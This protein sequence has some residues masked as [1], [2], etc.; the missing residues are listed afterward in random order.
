MKD[1]VTDFH[2]A[3]KQFNTLAG[4]RDPAWLTDLRTRGLSRFQS[5]GFPT[6]RDEDW[7]YTSLKPVQ[8][9]DFSLAAIP[10][11]LD[12]SSCE[13]AL[14]FAPRRLVFVNGL[15]SPEHSSYGD[16]PDGLTM[17]TLAQAMN[18]QNHSLRE[19][20]S[21]ED[22][23]SE[24]TFTGLN[25]AFLRD[26]AY[27][28]LDDHT[29][30]EQPIHLLYIFTGE[31]PDIMTFP[32]NVISIGTAASATILETFIC[33][34]SDLCYFNNT[35]TDVFL[36]ENAHLAYVKAQLNS[37]QAFHID[38]TR[39]RQA[40]SSRLEAFSFNLGARIARNNLSINLDGPDIFTGLDGL[41]AVRENQHVDNHT[42]VNHN[43]PNCASSQLYKGILADH[44][45][46]VFNGKIFVKP[47]AQLTNAY[48]LNRNLMLSP[49]AEADTKP[50]L[51]I[52]A[53]DVRCTHGATIGQ[54][55]E[56]ELFYLRSRGITR[57]A[58]VSMLSHGF[59]D[60]VLAKIKNQTIRDRLR[61][62]LETYFTEIE[63]N[64]TRQP[65]N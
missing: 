36:A 49:N 61:L 51:E 45:R 54:L 40:T 13:D 23:E 18:E 4:P 6:R 27:I 1:T 28:K 31:Q 11:S 9:R 30:C 25:T 44:S 47:A 57:L 62:E 41:Y 38:N 8:Q 37:F 21:C 53:D 5:L 55:N 35:F 33:T 58:A 16:L 29:T 63:K 12:L 19:I 10:D 48:Q 59:A 52:Y 7:K 20:L 24:N 64:D 26:G 15:F 32:R 17:T 46:G 34:S 50:Q 65:E 56:D 43:H 39:I 42:L 2:K 60:D 14:E 22:E 3:F